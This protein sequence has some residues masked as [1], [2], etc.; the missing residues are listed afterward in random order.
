MSDFN[1]PHLPPVRFVKTLLE[2]DYKS[3]VVEV[4][5]D[6]IPT[7]GM[8]VEAATQSSSGIKDDDK[9]ERMG[10]VVSLRNIKLIEEL[11]SK[12]FIVHIALANKLD[13]FKSLSFEIY[14]DKT[15]V[16]TGAF[17]LLLQ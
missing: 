5:F 14:K 17:T 16:A 15:V 6:E 1:V 9:S 13:Y 2:S 3:A 12:E 4:G 11:D 10:F 8:L 7:L